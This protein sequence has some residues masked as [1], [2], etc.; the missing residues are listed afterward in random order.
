MLKR[1]MSIRS[2]ALSEYLEEF[3]KQILDKESAKSCA[4]RL[5]KDQ[6]AF[7][8]YL[9]RLHDT[10]SSGYISRDELVEVLRELD[11]YGSDTSLKAGVDTMMTLFDKSGDNKISL[12]EF[13]VMMS[14]SSDVPMSKEEL[15][16]SFSVFDTN[17]DGFVDAKGLAMALECVGENLLSKKECNEIAYSLDVDKDGQVSVRI[18]CVCV[19]V[20]TLFSFSDTCSY[21]YTYIYRWKNL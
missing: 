9:F 4:E 17:Q 12:E 11:V 2:S 3:K 13:M 8:Q 10:D 5:S 18:L 20:S 15:R 14:F 7:L 6:K 19:C 16:R 21:F 1:N